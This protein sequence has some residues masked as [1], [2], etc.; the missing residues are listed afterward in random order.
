ME[1]TEKN[2]IYFKLKKSKKKKNEF[3]EWNNNNKIQL[4]LAD[5]TNGQSA[6]GEH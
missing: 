4:S 5:R 2:D 3:K 6:M 1:L